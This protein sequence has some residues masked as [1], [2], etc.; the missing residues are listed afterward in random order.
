MVR[1]RAAT[2]GDMV[3]LGKHLYRTEN[4]SEV[5]AHIERYVNTTAIPGIR[6]TVVAPRAVE[7]KMQH[8]TV[9]PL[10]HHALLSYLHSRRIDGK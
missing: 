10:R 3:E 7:T 6:G 5:L 1:L 4:V 8:I 2:G 9:V